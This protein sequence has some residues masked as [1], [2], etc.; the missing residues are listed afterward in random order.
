VARIY[1]SNQPQQIIEQ[2]SAAFALSERLNH[3]F[4][5]HFSHDQSYLVPPA[6][7]NLIALI[8]LERQGARITISTAIVEDRPPYH[9]VLEALDETPLAFREFAAKSETP[10]ITL[11]APLSLAPVAIAKPW[12]QEIWYTGIEARGQSGVTAQGFTVPLPW[13]L[14]LFPDVLG[15]AVGR[16]L[17]LL[18]IL[19]PLPDEV[20][21]DLYVEVHNLKREVYIVTGVDERAWPDQCGAIKLGFDQ[22]QRSYCDSDKAFREKY[23]AA[24]DAYR[25]VRNTI[26]EL[27]DQ[28]RVAQG[29][30]L[31]QPLPASLL[32]LWHDQLPAELISQEQQTRAAMDCFMALHPLRVGD[33]VKIPCGVPH[34]LQHGVR[35]V[36]FQTP[37]YER[38]ILSFAQKV[39]TQ[40]HWDTERALP[41]VSLSAP[42]QA[43]LT[44]IEEESAH[45]KLEHVAEFEDFT[46]E[47]LTLCGQG[48]YTI[49]LDNH[50][51]LLLLV[52]GKVSVQS[53]SQTDVVLQQQTINPSLLLP[54]TQ[55]TVTLVADLSPAVLLIARPV[56]ADL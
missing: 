18:K 3:C 8:A 53:P 21:G 22:Q 39:L 1:Q 50:Y 35:T 25:A 54:A 7:V 41:T 40:S 4:V 46:V 29:F 26:D 31:N 9:H 17:I 5:V 34:A 30:A 36:E 28:L 24:V 12:G 43:A 55:S 15:R 37:V 44:L 10:W 33:V 14:A 11:N 56:M 6:S 19:D 42:E 32:K 20:Y 13:L 48:K 2:Q 38:Q 52:S 16:D 51:A 47:R 23:L 49:A 27:F 45:F